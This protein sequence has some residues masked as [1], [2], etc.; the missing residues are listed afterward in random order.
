MKKI[1]ANTPCLLSQIGHN[2]FW[3]PQDH[4]LGLTY[5]IEE[6]EEPKFKSWTCGNPN[7]KALVLSPAYLR[8][9]YGHPDKEVVVW[10]R[11][12]DLKS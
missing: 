8:D 7:L 3:Y 2:N 10:I 6:I 11:N 1:K 12:K 9:V 5:I 4:E